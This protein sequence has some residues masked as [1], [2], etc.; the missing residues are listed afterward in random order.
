MRKSKGIRF[1]S[2]RLDSEEAGATAGACATIYD[3]GDTDKSQR[4]GKREDP[5]QTC[6]TGYYRVHACET[7]PIVPKDCQYYGPCLPILQNNILILIRN[8]FSSYSC[9]E[10]RR[11]KILL[12]GKYKQKEKSAMIL[13]LIRNDKK[14]GKIDFFFKYLLFF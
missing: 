3:S 2:T 11:K 9:C 4:P 1:V 13:F 7:L 10:S 8:T 12:I 5:C 6:P 14:W